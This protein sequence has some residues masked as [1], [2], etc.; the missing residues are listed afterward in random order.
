MKNKIL[1]I[2]LF[3]GITVLPVS[4][5]SLWIDEATTAFMASQ[6]SFDDLYQTLTSANTSEVQMPG[7]ILFIWGWEKISGYSEYALRLSNV[8]FMALVFTF[9]FY[10]P[11]PNRFKIIA[12]T[13]IAL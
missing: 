12:S 2:I 3:T 10:S 4:D 11:L 9:L 7:Y 1:L 13:I 8:F 5:Y 6:Q